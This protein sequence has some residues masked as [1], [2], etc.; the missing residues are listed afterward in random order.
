MIFNY[1]NYK[2]NKEFESTGIKKL[3]RLYSAFKAANNYGIAFV[4]E[5]D[6]NINDIYLN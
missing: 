6:S 2:V 1:G 4:D 5:M 3:V